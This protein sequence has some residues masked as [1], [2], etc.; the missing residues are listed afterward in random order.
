MDKY[1]VK[2]IPILKKYGVSRASLFGSFS[3]GKANEKSDIDII[4]EPAEGTTLFDLA[5]IQIDLQKILKKPVDL[6]TYRS[7]NK[8]LKDRIL[9]EEKVIY[10]I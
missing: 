6:L 4:I 9:K 1:V 5:G 2:I 10:Q 3:R 8:M 7:I